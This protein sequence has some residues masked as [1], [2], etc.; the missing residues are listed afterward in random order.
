[1]PVLPSCG[2]H[3]VCR[4]AFDVLY[5]YRRLSLNSY[6][7]Q[8]QQLVNFVC[9]HVSLQF[10]IR[11]YRPL[12]FTSLSPARILDLLLRVDYSKLYFQTQK[13]YRKRSEAF[14]EV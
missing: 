2:G 3:P 6:I 9:T 10:S 5:F 12:A 8:E 11:L 14:Q 1:M 13:L 7:L 4:W